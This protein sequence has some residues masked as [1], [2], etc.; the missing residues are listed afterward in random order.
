MVLTMPTWGVREVLMLGY[1]L[2]FAAVTL[3]FTYRGSD[4]PTTLEWWGVGTGILLAIWRIFAPP[5]PPN[6]G[7]EG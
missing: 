7:G 3:I 5:A 4:V 1:G 2:L 6:S